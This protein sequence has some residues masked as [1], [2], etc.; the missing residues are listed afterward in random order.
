MDD[1]LRPLPA[2]TPAPPFALQRSPGTRLALAGAAGQ[3]L[4]LLLY[5]G[6]W[7]PVSQEQLSRY[8]RFLAEFERLEAGLAAIAPDSAWCHL[9][10]A[11]EQGLRFPL[12]ADVHPHGAVARAYGVWSEADGL[13][14]RALFVIDSRGV[15]RWSRG[16]PL[17]LVPSVDALISVL[18]RL[19]DA[20]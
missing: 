9:A 10:F 7:E 2:G 20:E 13:T 8:Q 16:Y 4:V 15:I 12:L 11:R 14:G 1:R 18:E 5:P 3:P 17:N 19:R 6:D